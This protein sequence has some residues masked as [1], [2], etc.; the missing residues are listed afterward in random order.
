MDDGQDKEK[1]IRAIRKK[2]QQIDKLKEKGGALDAEAKEKVASE[3][4]LLHELALLEG[5]PLPEGAA[6]VSPVSV[7]KGNSFSE[8]ASPGSPGAGKKEAPSASSA[9][10]PKSSE[11]EPAAEAPAAAQSKASDTESPN[12]EATEVPAVPSLQDVH[13]AARA[14]ALE[15]GPSDMGTLE[16]GNIEKRFKALQKKLRDIGKLHEKRE[17]LDKLQK[18]KLNGEPALI[19]EIENL[20][21]EATAALEKAA[22]E[23]QAREAQESAGSRTATVTPAAAPKA[24]G[25]KPGWAK[26]SE[27]GYEG[28]A[29]TEYR[30]AEKG[31]SWHASGSWSKSS[32]G[33]HWSSG[34]GHY[35]SE[36]SG[37]NEKHSRGKGGAHEGY[38][39]SHDDHRGQKGDGDGPGKRKGGASNQEHPHPQ[40]AEVTT[41]F[42]QQQQLHLLQVQAQATMQAALAPNLALARGCGFMGGCGFPG[43]P[44]TPA[45]P[46]QLGHAAPLVAAAPGGFPAMWPGAIQAGFPLIPFA[47]LLQQQAPVQPQQPAVQDQLKRQIEY[48]F[49]E[50][51]LRRDFYL[52]REMSSEGFVPLIV[53]GGFP[54]V[55]QLVPMSDGGPSVLQLLCEAIGQSDQLELDANQ[56]KVRRR[57]GWERFLLPAAGQSPT[58]DDAATS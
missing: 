48:Y 15:S 36:A 4:G 21:A 27:E 41:P 29:P 22:L 2:L 47:P 54:R 49:S 43:M 19:E 51:N 20:R 42:A 3:P 39:R 18:E 45:M 31:Q 40:P 32:R 8:G 14:K 53:I 34:D 26:G 52:R 58:S 6:P 9:A 38:A 24:K 13:A 25:S 28:R 55:Q 35:G 11:A 46:I 1:R 37:H 10:V 33:Q 44:L 57:T 16:S 30:K 12:A 56:T 23:R 17:S 5:T 7:L 50:E